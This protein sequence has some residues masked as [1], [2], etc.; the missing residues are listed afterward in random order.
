MVEKLQYFAEAE[1]L[2]E[3][4]RE[5]LP[6][7]AGV[8]HCSIFVAHGAVCCLMEQAVH[9]VQTRPTDSDRASF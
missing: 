6:L 7:R 8:L 4:I 1:R 5:Q 2:W 3:I 9:V